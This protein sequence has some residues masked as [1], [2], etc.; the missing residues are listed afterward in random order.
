L[1]TTATLSVSKRGG[2][3]SS[4]DLF[5]QRINQKLW[6]GAGMASAALIVA[7]E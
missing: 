6:Q 5:G 4:R 2:S 7:I 1:T 3:D